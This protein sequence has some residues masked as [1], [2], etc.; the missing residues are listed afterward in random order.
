MNCDLDLCASLGGCTD[1]FDMHGIFG[2][3]PL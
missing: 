2:G 3:V 1:S